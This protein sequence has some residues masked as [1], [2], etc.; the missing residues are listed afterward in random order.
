MNLAW[1]LNE[2]LDGII[3]PEQKN[4]LSEISVSGLAI[5][6][7]KVKAGDIFFAY[8]GEKEDG[9]NY[10][11]AAIANG[12]I[13][14]LSDNAAKSAQA[15]RSS[16]TPSIPLII[17]KDLR[18]KIGL[19]ADRFYHHPS[20]KLTVIA[21]TGTNGKTSITHF[22]A[23][24]LRELN[25][26]CGIIG[27]IGK[28]FYDNLSPSNNTT[29]DPITLQQTFY[30]FLN[31]G[32][33]A[34]AIE[35][36]S[37]AL[38][39]FRLI[40]TQIKIAIFT[41]LTRDHLDYHGDMETYFQAKKKLFL[42]AGLEFAILNADDPYSSRLVDEIPKKVKIYSYTLV[43]NKTYLNS[44]KNIPIVSAS[45]IKFKYNGLIFTLQSPWG[46]ANLKTRLMGNFNISN[47]LAALTALKLLDKP[48]ADLLE[49]CTKIDPVKGRMQTFGGTNK[50]LIVI[51]YAHTPDSLE[52]AL[53]N[54]R[55]YATGKLWCVFGC[56]GDRDK[57]KR[58]LMGQ[59]AERLSDNIIITDDN[60]RHEDPKAIVQDILTGLRCPWA[61]EI[62]HDRAIAIA[63][64]INCLGPEDVLLIAGKG[65]EDYQLAGDKKLHFSDAEEVLK[66][67]S[68]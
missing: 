21:V 50:P 52:K 17:E 35:V 23:Q 44:N 24:A 20:K 34:V 4:N 10:I 19:I 13:A 37:H 46:E 36:S 8:A 16:S 22:L 67:I 65:H 3:I 60:P 63:H 56:G 27:T 49:V 12:A 51:D 9:N 5:D 28:G 38:A 42:S 64:A 18:E 29:P 43:P 62:E 58:P 47:L 53:L 31:E 1:K 32:A 30:E 2:L 40:G 25:I 54:L 6:S 7:R 41:N 11:N 15:L 45:N 66:N 33:E 55:P 39:Q 26:K 68:T 48:W 57:G 61:A 59:I 14:I